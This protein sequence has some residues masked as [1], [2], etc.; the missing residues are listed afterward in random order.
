MTSLVS[1]S[2]IHLAF[3]LVISIY[4]LYGLVDDL[5]DVGRILKKLTLPVVFAYPLV[6]V[7]RS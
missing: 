3:I 6:S 7:S 4:S 5:V 2:A 1:L